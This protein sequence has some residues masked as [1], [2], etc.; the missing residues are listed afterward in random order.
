MHL[1]Y[2]LCCSLLSALV[3]SRIDFCTAVLTGCS[4]QELKKLQRI[5]DHAKALAIRCS[6]SKDANDSP[7]LWFGVEKRIALR[8]SLLVHTALHTKE[9][10]YLAQLLLYPTST[11]SLRGH[12]SCMLYIPK[13]RT[14]KA[15][16]MFSYA[17]ASTWN[18]IPA[19]VRKVGVRPIFREAIVEWL[20]KC[21]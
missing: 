11:R 2:K 7:S 12:D 21:H 4:K 14:E 15:R 6:K 17:A 19:D 9:P 13:F 20:N 5:I 8:Q 1:D 10:I 16:G 3:L 18:R